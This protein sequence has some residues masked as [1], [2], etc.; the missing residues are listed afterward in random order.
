MF[1]YN[2]VHETTKHTP[3]ELVFGKIARIPSNEQLALEDKLANY[4]DYL[5]NLVTQLHT[6][7]SNA[8]ENVI[9]AKHKSKK[10]YDKKVNPRIFRPGDHVFLLKGPNQ[11]NLGT[12]TPDRTKS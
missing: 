12:N 5:I 10:I 8:R 2:S 6:I 9:E 3:Y 4:D 7:Q 1:N 11:V